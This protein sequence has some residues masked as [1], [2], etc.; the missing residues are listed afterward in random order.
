[1]KLDL[2]SDKQKEEAIKHL[3]DMDMIYDEKS[4][5]EWIEECDHI[6]LQ[7]DIQD[8]VDQLPHDIRKMSQK[9]EKRRTKSINKMIIQQA[10][11]TGE[12]VLHE[13]F[14]RECGLKGHKLSG[15][16]K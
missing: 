5:N 7:R 4:M 8:H 3:E 16:Q 6:E 11:Q 13:G 10:Y 14:N 1:M 2:L 12:F 15:G 9:V